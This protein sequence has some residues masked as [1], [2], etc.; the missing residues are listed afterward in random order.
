M[1]QRISE[2]EEKALEI[3]CY[4]QKKKNPREKNEQRKRY[5]GGHEADQQIYDENLGQERQKGIKCTYRNNAQN[6]VKNL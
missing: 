5:V 2:H 6:F 1:R 3:I 4:E